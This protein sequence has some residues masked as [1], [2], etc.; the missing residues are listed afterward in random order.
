MN[1]FI[2]TSRK[3]WLLLLAL[4]AILSCRKEDIQPEPIGEPVPY[5]DA[6]KTWQ[7]LLEQSSCTYF[8]KAWERSA[9][10]KRL[11]DKGSAFY[12]LF[13]PTDKAFQDAGWTMDRI[14]AT[15]PEKLDTLLAYCTV[16]GRYLPGGFNDLVG[17]Q[18]LRTLAERADL[19]NF[20]TWSPYINF[21]FVGK[22]ADSLYI[23]GSGAAKWG[24]GMEGKN[25]VIYPV[26]KF[27][28]RPEK[29]MWQ[30]LLEDPRFEYFTQAM[31]ISDSLYQEDYR[32]VSSLGMIRSGAQ[33]TQFTLY[34]PTNDAFRKY[35]LRSIDDI[36]NYCMRTWP[37]PYPYED[38]NRYYHEPVTAMDSLLGPH[39]IEVRRFVPSGKA[40]PV[41]FSNDLLDNGAVLSGIL[42]MAGQTWSTPPMRLSLSFSQQNGRPLVKH[43]GSTATPAGLIE[44]DIRVTNGVI[45]VVDEL[46]KP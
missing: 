12:T 28:Q 4:L 2:D 13:I 3:Q 29:A 33:F 24:T 39:G 20:S 5:K 37:L 40:G 6:D 15:A 8:R 9:M 18:P 27:L 35:G 41:Y 36:R 16:A 38:E 25:G 21:L 1:P 43:L 23:N 31:L 14:N 10:N 42:L 46:F 30:Y 19:P 7:Q 32:Y 26:D 22:H 17:N 44:K 34:A 45:H 11:A